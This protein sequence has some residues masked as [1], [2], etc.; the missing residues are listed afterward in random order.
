M[1]KQIK[2]LAVTVYRYTTDCTNGG[3]TA[4]VDRIILVGEGIPEVFEVKENAIYL[5]LVRRDLWGKEYLHAEPVGQT[6]K[7]I[8][9]MAGGNFIYSSDSRFR[10]IN[11]YPIPVHDRSETQAE[12]DTLSM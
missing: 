12:Y 10:K 2:G 1:K 11:A 4:K 7:D 9:D 3:I 5:K 6:K 8:G